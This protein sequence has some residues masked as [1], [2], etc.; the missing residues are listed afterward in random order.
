MNDP[1]A[2][3]LAEKARQTIESLTAERDALASALSG[4]WSYATLGASLTD[5]NTY[6]QP[7]FVAA[8]KAMMGD[9]G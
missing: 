5:V 7:Q 2:I 1:V 3:A 4:I 9:K 6:E 8:R